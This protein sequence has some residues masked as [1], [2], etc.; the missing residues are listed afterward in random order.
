[1]GEPTADLHYSTGVEPPDDPATGGREAGLGAD[2]DEAGPGVD[3]DEAGPD[4]DVD[5][6]A[7]ERYSDG[8]HR[9]VATVDT[10]P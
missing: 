5:E 9:S 6:A 1:M 4:V 7:L 3:V 10:A 2:V 8:R